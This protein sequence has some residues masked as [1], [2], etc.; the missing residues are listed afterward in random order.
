MS[1]VLANSPGAIEHVVFDLGGVLLTWNPDDILSGLFPDAGVRARVKEAVFQHN[2][3]HE[4]D[5]GT[6]SEEEATRR[7]IERTGRPAV[8]IERLMV[9]TM[10]YLQP[11]PE[12]MEIVDH[13]MHA[14]VGV[15]GL[16]NMR[17]RSLA[18]IRSRFEFLQKFRGMVA[19][20]EVGL[21]KPERAIYDYLANQYRIAPQETVF[22]DDHQPNV[23]G[24]RQAGLHAIWFR[25]AADCR[26][27]LREL[28]PAIRL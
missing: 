24:A 27:Q 13:L 23:D 15:Y 3:W 26:R 28:I 5:R 12:S 2:D 19:S 14:G 18:Y 17:A 8:E 11:M 22:I 9:R 4:L 1:A 20:C 21:L 16:S 10:E 7:F 25:S 6:F